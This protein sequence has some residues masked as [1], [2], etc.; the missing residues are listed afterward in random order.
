MIWQIN[1]TTTTKAQIAQGT[2]TNQRWTIRTT[3][4]K[5]LTDRSWQATH[6]TP[7]YHAAFIYIIQT[8]RN[9]TVNKNT[10]KH[11][12]ALPKIK[13]KENVWIFQSNN[14][15]SNRSNTTTS[16]ST[17]THTPIH[18]YMCCTYSKSKACFFAAD[19]KLSLASAWPSRQTAKAAAVSYL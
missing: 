16:Q 3:P 19:R 9:I 14:S 6:R 5:W 11:T 12:M 2:R 7:R 17:H 1:N 10:K 13:A 8:I 18:T 15:A 4:T